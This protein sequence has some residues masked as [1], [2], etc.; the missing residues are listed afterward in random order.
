MALIWK[1]LLVLSNVIGWLFWLVAAWFVM[2][3]IHEADNPLRH[4]LGI[5]MALGV[6]CGAFPA[7][8]S[9]AV[10]TYFRADIPK[11]LFWISRTLLPA[12]VFVYGIYLVASI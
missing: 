8:F 12:L 5:G 11:I 7:L 1:I 6:M 4:E 10:S 9:F 2:Q 3:Y